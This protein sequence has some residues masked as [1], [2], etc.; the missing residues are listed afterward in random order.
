MAAAAVSSDEHDASGTQYD[1]RPCCGRE[2]AAEPTS[3]T[4]SWRCGRSTYP[5]MHTAR[6]DFGLLETTFIVR[7][8][9]HVM[10]PALLMPLVDA[11][12]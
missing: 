11:T 5:L 7:L 12:G 4:R 6:T 9:I 1:S 8:L 2:S 3:T 10:P